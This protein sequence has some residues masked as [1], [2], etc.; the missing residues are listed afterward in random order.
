MQEVN[1]MDAKN[2]SKKVLFKRI[3]PWFVISV[4]FD[5]VML[6]NNSEEFSLGAVLIFGYFIFCI[7]W[8]Y[9]TIMNFKK[10]HNFSFSGSEKTK[11]DINGNFYTRNTNE[12]DFIHAMKNSILGLIVSFKIVFII[13]YKVIKTIVI[14]IRK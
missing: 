10:T 1:E 2:Q 5:I 7:P 6:I 11:Q 8:I 12:S 3:I 13:P 9:E 14:V 4:I